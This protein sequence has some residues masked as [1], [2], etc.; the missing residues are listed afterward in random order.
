MTPEQIEKFKID[1]IY[2]VEKSADRSKWGDGDWILNFV[3][4]HLAAQ[5]RIV[6]DGFVV[7]PKDMVKRLGDLVPCVTGGTFK[8]DPPDA[9][10]DAAIRMIAAA[11]KPGEK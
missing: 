8:N 11:P 2:A 3:I 5:D 10:I 9:V 7:V 4:D 6:P 1:I